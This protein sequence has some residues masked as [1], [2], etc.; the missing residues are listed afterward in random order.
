M[1]PSKICASR[2]RASGQTARFR[3]ARQLYFNRP[4]G[5]IETKNKPSANRLHFFHRL[6]IGK[7]NSPFG[8]FSE[9]FPNITSPKSGITGEILRILSFARHK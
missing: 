9:I 7:N 2:P 3:L 4:R 8:F 5:P 6:N 1:R